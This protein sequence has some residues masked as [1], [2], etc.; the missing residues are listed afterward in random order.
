MKQQM[1]FFYPLSDSDREVLVKEMQQAEFLKHLPELMQN[2]QAE[3][4]AL[5][6][7]VAELQKTVE[8]LQKSAEARAETVNAVTEKHAAAGDGRDTI[9]P[10]ETETPGLEIKDGVL[11]RYTGNADTVT[12][13]D[14]VRE[15]GARAFYNCS[16]L[17]Y[18]HFPATVTMIGAF[19]FSCCDLRELHLPAQLR[20]IGKSAF[21]DN[22]NLTEAD[23]PDP[24]EEIGDNAF[25][26]CD[27]LQKVYLPDSLRILGR[28]PFGMQSR[29]ITFT[30]GYKYGVKLRP[31][32]KILSVS[33][34]E[35][36]EQF[37]KIYKF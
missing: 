4:A 37:R 20:V 25:M 8:E 18:V 6:N 3:F 36:A 14:G 30:F 9:Q 34:P 17:N 11:I 24:T 33:C 7:T 21:A 13:P 5:Q 29:D 15:I 28:F 16:F 22:S 27:A 35:A 31:Y 23:I 1:R 26:G 32:Y 12:V 10:R 19:A 2:M